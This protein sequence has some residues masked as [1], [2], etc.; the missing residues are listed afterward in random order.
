[1]STHVRIGVGGWKVFYRPVVGAAVVA[2]VEQLKS[3]H[4]A[5]IISLKDPYSLASRENLEKK[6]IKTFVKFMSTYVSVG[7]RA[8]KAFY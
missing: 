4:R 5:L 8:W 1:M 3:H 2:T 7:A 6:C